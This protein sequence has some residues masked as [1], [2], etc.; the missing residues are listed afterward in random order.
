MR[1]RRRRRRRRGAGGA[2]ERSTR[3]FAPTHYCRA[4]AMHSTHLLASPTHKVTTEMQ[5]KA[6][7]RKAKHRPE[8]ARSWHTSSTTEHGRRSEGV[9]EA[10]EDAVCVEAAG[11]SVEDEHP[12]PKT[13]AARNHFIQLCTSDERRPSTSAYTQSYRIALQSVTRC[14]AQRRGERG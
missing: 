13:M 14:S 10:C 11:A 4:L 8:T 2:N 1:R 7:Q 12:L 5:R 6:K 3:T 9:S